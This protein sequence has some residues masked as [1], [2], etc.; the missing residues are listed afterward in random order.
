M[1]PSC[2]K[3]AGALLLLCMGAGH[4]EPLRIAAAANFAPVLNQLAA[5]YQQQCAVPWQI[6]SASSGQLHAQIM[7]G[8]PF[9]VFLSA[10]EKAVDE[11]P[12]NLKKDTRIYARGRLALWFKGQVANNVAWQKGEVRLVMANPVTAPYGHAAQVYLQQLAVDDGAYVRANNIQQAYLLVDQGTL[13]GGFVALSA[14]LM[15]Q[16][17]ASEYIILQD[18]PLL[19][20]K[21]AL[22]QDNA[23][24][25]CFWNWLSA[26]QTQ[27]QIEQAGYGIAP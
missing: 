3:I 10:D 12:V 14:L 1:L 13:A 18:V 15:N 17:P 2:K 8:A 11:L 9:S 24:S 7:N 4:A 27:R 22:L 25:R 26:A 19:N 21:A 23:A 16:R 6:S 5:A 20:Q